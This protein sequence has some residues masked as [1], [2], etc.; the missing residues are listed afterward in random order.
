VI[1][2]RPALRQGAETAL[3]RDEDLY[4]LDDTHWNDAGIAVAARLVA[5]AP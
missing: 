5:G 3:D 4:W 1:N 2:T